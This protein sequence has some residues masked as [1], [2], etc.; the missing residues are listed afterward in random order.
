MRTARAGV[1]SSPVSGQAYACPSLTPVG[2]T[3]F[4]RDAAFGYQSSNLVHWIRE[5]SQAAVASGI[6]GEDKAAE[7]EGLERAKSVVSISLQDLRVGGAGV[8]RERLNEG[9]EGCV[10]VNAIEHRDLQV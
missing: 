8:V 9:R 6:Y 2:D 10:V 4:A 3:E 1:T 5:K 7:A